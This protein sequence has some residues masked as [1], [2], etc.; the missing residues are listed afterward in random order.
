MTGTAENG[1]ELVVERLIDAPP[2]TV[3]QIMTERLTEWWCP[4]PW[5]TEIIEQDWRPGGRSALVMRGPEGEEAPMEG[6]FLEVVPNTRFVFTN[7]F[8]KGWIP[9]APF[10]VGIFELTPEGSGTRYRACARHWDEATMKQHEAMGFIDGWTT[11][12]NQL[13][14][15]AE[16]L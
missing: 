14:E 13:A 12:A 8:T 16:T 4:K 5:K 15:I 7:A 11:V 2:E 10:M 9:A 3:W 6:V 1:F